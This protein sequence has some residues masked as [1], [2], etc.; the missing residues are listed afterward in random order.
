M[1]HTGGVVLCGGESR[2]M[3]QSKA[4]LDFDGEPMLGRVVRVVHEVVSPV[5]VAHHE[6]QA[7]PPLPEEIRLV[8]DPVSGVGPLAGLLGGLSVLANSCDA[9]FVCACDQPLLKAAFVSRLIERLEHHRAVMVRHGD[10]L[11]V[12]TA[13][14]RTDVVELLQRQIISGD[15]RVREFA[16][17]CAPL[18]VTADTFR[19]IDSK[20][21]SLRNFNTAQDI[22]A[23]HRKH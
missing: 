4:W 7:L 9:A 21:D 23:H 15:H 16:R 17:L 12:L 3:G 1:N 5:V 20:V 22:E 13:V 6:G 10:R 18:I 14:Y 19:D 2:R 11:H 8:S